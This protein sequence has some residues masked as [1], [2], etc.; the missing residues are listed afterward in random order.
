M[1]NAQAMIGGMYQWQ[2][3]QDINVVLDR[4]GKEI[5]IETVLTQS[6]TMSNKLVES[7]NATAI[8]IETRQSW[9][10]G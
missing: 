8:Q 7:E 3:G 5:I 1:Q 4:D 6:F 2:P 9:L 10:K